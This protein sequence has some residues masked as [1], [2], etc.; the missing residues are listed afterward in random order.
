MEAPTQVKRLRAEID[1][2]TGATSRREAAARE[3][4][5]REREARVRAALEVL[6]ELEDVERRNG[7]DPDTARASTTDPRPG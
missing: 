3:R 7:D 6:P 5:A 1:D 2:D 4:T